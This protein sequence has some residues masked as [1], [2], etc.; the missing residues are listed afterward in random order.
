MIDDLDG[1]HGL[2]NQPP[3]NSSG[4]R[5]S[6]LGAGGKARLSQLLMAGSNSGQ[7]NTSNG[8]NPTWAGHNSGLD[9]ATSPT[10]GAGAS[11]AG[12]PAAG[13]CTSPLAA[14]GASVSALE[15]FGSAPLA[16]AAGGGG[17]AAAGG[18]AGG[19]VDGTAYI[20]GPLPP[21]LSQVAGQQAGLIKAA[22]DPPAPQAFSMHEVR[23]VGW[24]VKWE[25]Q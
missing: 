3:T 19:G 16:G 12:A 10:A 21:H 13:A 23:V 25:Q 20:R 2:T 22:S 7:T 14:A 6:D 24:Q 8:V 4:G 1:G 17:T 5:S 9:G 11:A 15:A 18:G